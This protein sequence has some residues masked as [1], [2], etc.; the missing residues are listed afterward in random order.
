MAACINT[1]RLENQKP[2]IRTGHA[3]HHLSMANQQPVMMGGVAGLQESHAHDLMG[4]SLANYFSQ[5]FEPQNNDSK[6]NR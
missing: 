3:H 1:P 5:L 2:R 4:N 6:E